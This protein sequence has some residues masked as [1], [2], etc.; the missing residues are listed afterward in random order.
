MEKM[1][2]LRLGMNIQ[3]LGGCLTHNIAVTHSHLSGGQM[4]G[5][6]KQKNKINVGSGKIE[7]ELLLIT[8]PTE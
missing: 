7:T 3:L 2:L 1:E 6:N 5:N 8:N 4:S